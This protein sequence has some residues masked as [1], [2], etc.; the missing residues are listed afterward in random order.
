MDEN[1]CIKCFEYAYVD[2][3]KKLFFFDVCK[4]KICKECLD[5]HLSKHNKQYCPFCKVSITKTNVIPID[6]DEWIYTNQK[7][8]RAK[9]MSIFNK[10]RHNF[11]NTPLYNN[12]L[13]KVEDLIYTLSNETDKKKIKQL[14]SYIKKYEKENVKIIEENNAILNEQKKRKIHEIVQEEGNFYEIIKHRPLAF[15]SIEEKEQNKQSYVHNLIKE[16][17]KLFHEF[18]EEEQN[19][20]QPQPL[21]PQYKADTDIPRQNYK[22]K[23]MAMKADICGGYNLD[24]VYHRAYTEFNATIYFNID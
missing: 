14:E 15:N 3:D 9:L 13:E 24:V 4:H 8:I 19:Q 22:T 11:E 7:K 20:A 12:Y 1:K 6:M 5:E 21:N 17:P 2:S 18:K 23:Q 16:N 10:K